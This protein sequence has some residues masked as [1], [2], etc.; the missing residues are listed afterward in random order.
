MRKA[1]D[2][3]GRDYYIPA[4]RETPLV[5]PADDPPLFSPVF[6]RQIPPEEEGSEPSGTYR[7]I[8]AKKGRLP[9]LPCQPGSMA[10]NRYK[11]VGLG[12]LALLAL[13]I[14]GGIQIATPAEEYQLVTKWGLYSP[15]S[16]QVTATYAI[17]ADGAG[18]VYVANASNERI[19]KFTSDGTF[20]K[21]WGGEQTYRKGVLVTWGTGNGQFSL[22]LGIAVDNAGDV[23]VADTNNNRVQKFDSNGTFITTWG[24]EGSGDGQFMRPTGITVDS[25]GNV[26]VVD[27][28]TCLV[29]KFTSTG[30]FIKAWGG[31]GYIDGTFQKP[32]DIAADKFGNVYVTDTGHR[33]I[34][35]FKYDGTF[36]TKWGL[37]A[38]WEL[39][40]VEYDERWGLPPD[41]V[42]KAA[43]MTATPLTIAVD[44]TGNVYVTD[45]FGWVQKFTS[46]GS[47]ITKWDVHASSLSGFGSGLAVDNLGNVYVV[48]M[49]EPWLQK[50][51]LA[52]PTA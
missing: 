37:K 36:V 47:L 48:R 38:N 20:V 7:Y 46:T 12:V 3:L 18:N 5:I 31:R 40:D 10:R 51:A 29:Q 2:R 23:Y 28:S 52:T 14:W 45:D 50:Y 26:Y 11:L 44:N 13:L 25:A 8:P 35:K 15:V 27:Y 24:S 49:G 9:T 33:L 21:A 39:D 34:Q 17:A 43:G 41:T 32:K 42:D 4:G 1:A 6:D 16:S 30:S 19:E 22:P